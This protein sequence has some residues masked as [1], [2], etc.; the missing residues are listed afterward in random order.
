[1]RVKPAG[2]LILSAVFLI[3]LLAGWFYQRGSMASQVTMTCEDMTRTCRLEGTPYQL[4][5]DR[6]PARLSPFTLTIEGAARAVEVSFTMQGMDMGP[7]NYVLIPNA[8]RTVWQAS[9][10]L[11]ACMTGRHDWIMDVK[12]NGKLSGQVAFSN[13]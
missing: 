8:D 1:M 4:H 10:I 12:I 2:R 11:P 5:T 9:I 7:N 13:K 3:M 6:H